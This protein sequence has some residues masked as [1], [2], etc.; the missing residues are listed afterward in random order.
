MSVQKT[1]DTLDGNEAAASVAYRR[2][3]T[4]KNEEKDIQKEERKRTR[5]MKI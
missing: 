2:K 1:L 3:A 5:N 4:L